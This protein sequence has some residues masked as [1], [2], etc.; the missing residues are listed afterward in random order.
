MNLQTNHRD[1]QGI[2]YFP[3]NQYYRS[4]F[5]E[6]VYKIPVSIAETCPNREGLKGMKTCVFCDEWGSAAY[7]ERREMDLVQQIKVNRELIRKKNKAHKFLVYFQAYTN[8][9]T[10]VSRLREQFEVA[11]S[12]MDVVGITVGTRPDCVSDS[13]FQLWNEFSERVSIFVELGVQSFN[14]EQLVWMERGHSGEKSLWAVEKIREK[15]PNVNLGV[16]LMFGLPG[17]TEEQVKN[18][19]LLCSQLPIDNVKLHNTHV[20][21]DTPLAEMYHRGEFQPI[22]REKYADRV[23]IFLEHLRPDIS[24]HRLAAVASRHDELV[25]PDWA[26]KRMENYQFILDRMR[27]RQGYQ[28][29]SY[30]AELAKGISLADLQNL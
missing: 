15:C 22:S 21:V 30:S 8:T 4:E 17:E 29:K 12:F 26:A 9:F 1:W 23:S 13:V 28:G 24:V 20:L 5:G 11:C 2:P 19:A 18:S 6:K 25:A 3:I 27:D 7:P 10:K 16:H 14:N